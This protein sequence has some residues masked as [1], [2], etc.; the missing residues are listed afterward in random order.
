MDQ[1]RWKKINNI[2]DTALDLSEKERESYIQEKCKDNKQLK[3]EV[4][5]LIASIEQSDTE[6]FLEDLGDYTQL[7]HEIS[8]NEIGEN[9]S[10]LI[11]TTIDSYKLIELIGHGGMGSVFL[12]ERADQAY[13]QK[14]ALKLMRRGM[15]TPSNI[16]RF[17]RERNILAKLNHPN[18]ARLLDGG[19][20][21]EGLP[22]LV[23][24]Y[25]EGT[26]LYN[27]CDDNRLSI[28][29]RLELFKSI[30][31][32]VHH[33]HNNA[34]IHRDLK[35][36]NIL[37]TPN[38]QVKILDF[39]IAKLLEP[40]D[41]NT[42]LFETQTGA[43]I[44]TLGYAAPEQ[45]EKE[46]I[47]THTDIYT[48]G[49]LLY[50]LLAGV[51]PF[52]MDEKS[53]TDI[54]QLIREETPDKPSNRFQSLLVNRKEKV[55]DSR[56]SSPEDLAEKLQGDLDAIVMKALRKEP[57]ARY[58]SAEKLLVDLERL[59]KNLPLVA[60]KDTVRYTIGKFV[61]RHK[62][63]IS[64]AAGFFLLIIGFATFYTLQ[65]SKE[66]NQAQIQAE[67]AQQVSQFILGLFDLE[68]AKDTLQ[69]RDVLRQGAKEAKRL[70]GEPGY[71]NMLSVI[72]QAHTNIGDYDS[73]LPLL[74]KAVQ[75]SKTLHGIQ[76]SEHA[77]AL[78]RLGHWYVK[79][80]N[81]KKALP[82][83][84]KAYQINL[85]I[86][87]M[88]D[89][90]TAMVLANMASA[91]RDV[92]KIDSAEIYARKALSIQQNLL[93]KTH[94]SVLNT[95]VELGYVLRKKEE[96][97]KAESLYVKA[98][99]RAKQD[100][101]NRL[102]ML[103]GY[104]QN[105]GYLYRVQE[106][107][108]K[109]TE[110]YRTSIRLIKAINGSGHPET[111]MARR[112][113]AT[114]LYFQKNYEEATKLLEENINAARQ[115]FGTNHTQTVSTINIMSVFLMLQQK[116][117]KA[118]PYIRESVQINRKIRGTDD[119]RT[120]YAE[121][122]LTASLMLQ[123]NTPIKETDSLKKHHYQFYEKHSSNLSKSTSADINRIIRIYQQAGVDK[124]I[125]ADYKRLLK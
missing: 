84:R 70:K 98:I 71:A 94:P 21:E 5:E 30:C 80:Y 47:T 2:V 41:P 54:E 101:T 27:Y 9:T 50:E 58:P 25:V 64:V 20:T 56:N 28:D 123:D 96:Y 85:S 104:Y 63:G 34:I 116:F 114:N 120:A 99:S 112:N 82:F 57:E 37:V 89:Q 77:T 93:S 65:I 102:N 75:T 32:A 118:E 11:G 95:M 67:K 103:A 19:M 60:R 3:R 121:G 88:E 31:E 107:H 51:H 122:L 61:K 12:A 66:R 10:S 40:E 14:V 35:P 18:I 8:R 79:Q 33:A 113:L 117:E 46:S 108:K 26:P 86:H 100:S 106:N 59:K 62:Y 110:S 69:V 81:F 109:A 1:Q 38:G 78:N 125:V 115:R 13:E 74:Q 87:G 49:I 55:A 72:G 68:A 39:G 90:N 24:E 44:L 111:I 29:K 17:K 124:K 23:M 73:A 91:M 53:F 105:L 97:A 42:Q 43:R 92:G 15:D 45:I 119:L 36:S 16:A 4:T 6:N 48:L 83:F 7:A 22:Y 76:S 52:D